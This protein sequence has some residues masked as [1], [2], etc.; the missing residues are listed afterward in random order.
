MPDNDD[1]EDI[2]DHEIGNLFKTAHGSNLAIRHGAVTMIEKRLKVA[3][4]LPRLHS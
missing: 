3:G 2:M 1:D 4:P